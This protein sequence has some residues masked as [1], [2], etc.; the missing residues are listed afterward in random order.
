MEII[1]NTPE[2]L[3]IRMPVNEPLANSI[4]RSVSEV[5]S[6]AIDEVEIFKND[7]A[8]F[9]EMIAH[10][11]GLIPL[12]TEKNM[13]EKTKIEFKLTKKGPATVYSGDLQGSGEVVH[14]NIPITILREDHKLELVA[15]ARLGTGREHAKHIPG[16]CF[17]R[18]LLEVKSSQE[19]D[20]IVQNSKGIIKAEK[21]GGKW[22]CDLNDSE[23]NTLTKKDKEA[24]KD[25]DEI[26]FVIESYGNMPAKE[27]LTKAVQALEDNL[28]EFD[29]AIK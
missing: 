11:L 26:I 18:H 14:Q 21:K 1:T 27:I 3:I 8:L 29:K 6:L 15:T 17:Y 5:P 7:S 9:D 28:D 24:V 22:I 23:V 19:A 20:K 25:S 16:L 2:K 12:K 4:R 13:S 10:R